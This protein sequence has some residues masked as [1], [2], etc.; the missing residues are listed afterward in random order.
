[1][2]KTRLRQVLGP[3]MILVSSSIACSLALSAPMDCSLAKDDVEKTICSHPSLTAQDKAI[4]GRL[5][6]LG[7]AC[8]SLRPLL[9]QGQKYWL[10]ERWDCRNVEGVFEKAEGLASCL[11]SRMEQRLQRLNDEPQSCDPKPLVGGYRFVDPVYLLRYGD[12]YI[13]KTVSVYGSMVLDNCRASGTGTLTGSIVGNSPRHER[14]RAV[15][16]AMS[17]GA[18]ERLCAQHPAAHWQGVVKQ[19]GRGSYLVLPD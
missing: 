2:D 4:S 1:M 3:V 11:A 10:R 18:R 8:P 15:F 5:D 19:D 16:S 14:Y 17:E 7:R 13:G 6:A 12:Q 9:I